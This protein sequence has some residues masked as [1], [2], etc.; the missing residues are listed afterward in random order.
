MHIGFQK[1]GDAGGRGEYE[2]VGKHSFYNAI[3]LEGWR[4]SLLWPDGIVR[5]TGLVLEAGG[6]G[7]PRLRSDAPGHFQ[8]GRMIAAMLLLPDPRRAVA[9]TSKSIPVATSKGYILSRIGFGADTEFDPMTDLVT[10][11][12]SF[13]NLTNQ[14]RTDSEGVLTRWTRIQTVLH[15]LDEF[16]AEVQEALGTH[17]D[18]LRA[19]EIVT[20]QLTRTVRH[21]QVGLAR[22]QAGS[23]YQA[24]DDPLPEL[25]HRLDIAVP[26]VP[27]LPE[28]GALGQDE[29]EVSARSAHQYRLARVRG[30]GHRA[31]SLGVRDSYHQR[32]MFCG[33]RYGGV[34]GVTSGIDAA[35]IL[36]WSKYD[37]DVPHNGMSLCKT[38]HWAFDAALMVPVED[39]GRYQIRFTRLSERFDPTALRLLG[40]DRFVVPTDW[41]PSDPAS[42]PSPKYLGKLYADLAIE[43]CE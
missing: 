16:S 38:H 22:S 34:S 13:V 7:K 3:A 10:V 33:G 29:P 23:S 24:A 27:S 4:F 37:L 35:H 19:G 2:I 12:P 21:L 42:R 5:D 30:P 17:R 25:E 36:A 20:D 31:F 32:C 26:D 14:V 9:K 6:S 8:V 18:T 15:A 43:L 39:Q 28:P 11:E 1:S 41:L 40:T